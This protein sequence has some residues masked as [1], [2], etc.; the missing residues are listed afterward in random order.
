MQVFDSRFL[1]VGARI[2]GVL[3]LAG[4]ASTASADTPV[5]SEGR[6]LLPIYVASDCGSDEHEGAGELARILEAMSG[7]PWPVR[8]EE[9]EGQDGI[10]IGHTRAA[11]HRLPPL[12][13]ASDWLAPRAGEVGPDA[14][15]IRTAGGSVFIEG[16]TPEASFFAVAWLLMHEGGVRWYAPGPLDEFIPHRAEWSLPDLDVLRDPAYLSRELSGFDSPEGAAWARRNGLRGRLEFSHALN[17]VFPPEFFADHP[18]WFP[19]LWGRRFQPP[20]VANRD[21]QP[22]LALPGVADHAS[23]A[24]L[25]AF[26]REPARLSFSLGI[27]DTVRFDQGPETQ[28]LVEPM[29]YFRGMPDY[30]PL[31]FTFMNR[32]AASV[33]RVAP[34][35][36]L[37]CLAYFWCEN[38]PPFS[39]NRNVV[40]YV[41]ADRTQ[42]YD[43]DFCTNDLNLMSRWGASGVRAFGIW[44]YAYGAGFVIPREPVVALADAIR[45]GWKRGARGYFAEVGPNPG[46]DAFK[47][48][49]MAQLLW[50]P[51]LTLSDLEDDFFRGYYG[52][53]QA[54]M[55]RFFEACQAL[56]MTQEGAPFWLKYYGQEDQ[57]LLFPAA[58]CVR[59]RAMLTEAG[60]LAA[61][62]PT[63]AARVDI[64]SREFAV[65]EAYI[66]FDS[67]RR[68][69]AAKWP[70][71]TPDLAVGEGALSEA[72]GVLAR[73]RAR[74]DTAL[75][76]AGLDGS[77]PA[78]RNMPA[79]LLRNDPVP[80]LL[81]GAGRRDPYAPMR[82]LE[83][84]GPEAG[85]QSPWRAVADGLA[86]GLAAAPNLTANSSFM[87]T[88]ANG[89]E[90]SYL[91]PRFGALPA[92]W[93]LK[94]MPT[95]NGRAALAEETRSGGAGSRRRSIRIEGAWD[96][97]VYQ[98]L[99][100][101]PGFVYLAT[102]RLKG[103]SSPGCDAALFLTFLSGGGDVL[104]SWMQSLPKGDAPSWH[105]G[106]L[107]DRAPAQAAW[108]GVGVG[109]SRQ[110]AGDW[111][112]ADSVELRSCSAKPST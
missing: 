76:D 24:A 92:G 77:K 18:D 109:C 1:L 7:L 5:F 29:R 112:E 93:T 4:W 35:R 105:T 42:Y 10:F 100:T 19:L 9:G 69:L 82:I 27:N 20:S 63:C 17:R 72:I 38:P 50:D 101:K 71:N 75:G 90:P 84:V 32:A 88:A 74:L 85:V 67:E 52:P 111:M 28:R 8:S 46:F 108:V 48:W 36:Y 68:M 23:R 14:F 61:A 66:A 99:P 15:R 21:W 79:S 104:A 37:G 62:E 83:A 87:E 73:S 39:V 25:E 60:S 59:L 47:A 81:F 6:I 2:S 91:Y 26:S 80:R 95:E 64:S 58:T 45:E 43:R 65:T 31:V 51:R 49:A 40:P 57:A 107:G 44:E 97:Q 12:V 34:E 3:T 98:W 70:E 102:A 55:R 22:N 30:S 53:A 89:Q 96:T 11:A 13:L 54:P 56:W 106:A 110:T 86:S 78:Q 94:A 33:S 41:T 16:A 103:R